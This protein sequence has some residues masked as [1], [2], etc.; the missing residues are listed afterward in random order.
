MAQRVE[1]LA[2]SLRWLRLLLWRRLL[3]GLGPSA[4]HGL[5]VESELQLL[6]YAIATA[7]PEPSRICDLHH[8]SRQCR[9]LSPL[10]EARDQTRILRDIMSGS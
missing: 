8:R 2:L 6:A 9:I 5:E 10:K 7:T 3:H 4:C 1:D